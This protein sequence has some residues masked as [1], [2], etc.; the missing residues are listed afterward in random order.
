MRNSFFIILII[1]VLIACLG[2]LSIYSSTYQKEG[3]LWQEI[4]KRQIL[5]MLLGLILFLVI[6]NF[7]YRHLWDLTYLLYAFMLFILFLVFSLGAVRSVAL[8]WIRLA[9]FTFH[10]AGFA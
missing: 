8:R 2:I 10:S 9:W 6:S 7:N 1:A 5:W 3:K 4:Y